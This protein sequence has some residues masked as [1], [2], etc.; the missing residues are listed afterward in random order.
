M[1]QPQLQI[2]DLVTELTIAAQRAGVWGQTNIR[3]A[4]EMLPL[5]PNEE[6]RQKR[7]AWLLRNLTLLATRRG[8]EAHP[9]LPYSDA[10]KIGRPQHDSLILGFIDTLGNEEPLPVPLPAQRLDRQMLVAGPPGMGKSMLVFNIVLQLTGQGIPVWIFDTE[11]EYAHALSAFESEGLAPRLLV[12]RFR[13]F[14]RNPFDGP[15]NMTQEEWLDPMTNYCRPAFFFRD[16][17]INLMRDRCK[18]VLESGQKLNAQTF[19]QAY[20]ETPR[21]FRRVQDYFDTL[22]RLVYV[23]E[24]PTYRCAAGFDLAALSRQTV[25]FDLQNLA[26]DLRMFFISDLLNWLDASR[27]YDPFRKLDVVVVMDE[28]SKFVSREAANRSDFGEPPLLRMLRASRKKGI[29]FILADQVYHLFH[30]V[31]RENCQTKIIFETI[32]GFSKL[33]IARD[34]S[35]NSEQHEYLGQLSSAT[36]TR[37]ALVKLPHHPLPILMNIPIIEKPATARPYTPPDFPWTPLP[38]LTAEQKQKRRDRDE[39]THE[40]EFYLGVIAGSWWMS[41][42]EHD[43]AIKNGGRKW[44]R[45]K[46]TRVRD[47]LKKLGLLEEHSIN[48]YLPGKQIDLMVP[49]TAGYEFLDRRGISYRVPEGDGKT[50]HRWWQRTIRLG[51][52]K[53]GCTCRIEQSLNSKRVDVGCITSLGKKI[54]YEV[55]MEGLEKELENLRDLEDGWDRI[56]FCVADEETRQKLHA[57]LPDGIQNVEIKLLKEFL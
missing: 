20:A 34:L 54:A 46:G 48:L 47:D 25:V 36:E 38:E 43:D 29:G 17:S 3:Q 15:P 53:E 52:E 16:G 50:P 45:Q 40:M 32:A 44:S 12:T 11:G 5:I 21:K 41:K 10:D 57:I 22:K 7:V 13:D 1:P 9:F 51:M 39:V 42:T 26:D 19:T 14:R 31:V 2:A 8:A 23:L 27:A 4:I 56:V 55:L 6:A 33:D 18:A 49:T 37:R 35:L 30:D 24:K 28:L